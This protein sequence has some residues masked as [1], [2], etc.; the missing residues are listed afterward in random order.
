[1]KQLVKSELF[2]KEQL[3]SMI[4]VSW[5]EHYKN[6]KSI[7]EE[8]SVNNVSKLRRDYK[9]LVESGLE[10]TTN[11]MEMKKVLDR[12]DS[13]SKSN[14]NANKELKFIETL[15]SEIPDVMII[16]YDKLFEILQKFNLSAGPISI[17]KGVIP[18]E[19]I[20]IMTRSTEVIT[21]N[22]LEYKFNEYRWIKQIEIN[23][24]KYD[25]KKVME[26]IGRFPFDYSR[27]DK[28]VI[29]SIA[30]K[31]F[32]EFKYHGNNTGSRPCKW[33]DWVIIAPSDELKDN[34]EIRVNSMDKPKP[35]KLV[36]DPIVGKLTE[37]GFVSFYAWG[38]EAKLDIYSKYN[39]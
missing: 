25:L 39:L 29:P 28:S 26:S 7:S 15:K 13:N 16:P 38:E 9:M 8:S 5:M 30:Y 22:S 34:I 14:L 20:E 27:Y 4:L 19:A 10:L 17:Y 31:E 3:Q 37:Y 35:T 23:I 21:N 32:S 11:A 2:T 33:Q 12:I 1:M 36:E 6:L 18:E 24:K